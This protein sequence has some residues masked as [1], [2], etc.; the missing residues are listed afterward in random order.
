MAD[1]TGIQLDDG[2]FAASATE[3]EALGINRYAGAAN[4]TA[5]LPTAAPAPLTVEALFGRR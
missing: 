4:S 5:T 2:V 1:G 3:R